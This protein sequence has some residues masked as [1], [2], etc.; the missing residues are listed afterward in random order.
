MEQFLRVALS[1]RLLCG[2]LSLS[3]RGAKRGVY[4]FTELGMSIE[5][6]EDLIALT[7]NMDLDD[8]ILG[9]FDITKEELDLLMK[10][11]DIY[12][13]AWSVNGDHEITISAIDA[14]CEDYDR[15]S[16]A[17]LSTFARVLAKVFEADGSTC[18]SW[19]LYPQGQTKFIRLYTSW[20][21][22]G[23]TYYD[24]RYF[25]A[26][27]GKLINLVMKP[28][29]GPVTANEDELM[30][31]MID[32]VRFIAQPAEGGS[33]FHAPA[34]IYDDPDSGEEVNSL[35]KDGQ[36]VIYSGEDDR[37]KRGS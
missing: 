8:P 28:S 35:K 34:F 32:S 23:N 17:D 4:F 36:Y 29:L 13:N 22:D 18:L 21:E 37:K 1:G 12:L 7:R 2:L 9:V 30:K 26:H 11:Q 15:Y 14:T 33:L 31:R 5:P 20:A 3:A 16:D 27:G 24:V 6:S 25:T 19:E 10:E